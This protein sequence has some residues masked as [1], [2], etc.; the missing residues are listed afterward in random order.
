MADEIL[1]RD[2]NR[3]TVLGGVTDDA[4]QYITMLRVDPV[5]KRLLVSATGSGGGGVTSFNT[6][7][8][9]VVLAAGTN[10]TL[11]PVGNTITIASTGSGGAVDSVFGRTG[12]VTA[13]SGDY[14]TAIVADSSNKRYVTDAQLVVIGNT[15]GTNTGD[16]TNVTGNA[17]TATALQNTRTIWGQNFNGTAN[18]T[19]TLALGTAD[20]T[21]T[22][23]IGATGARATKVWAVDLEVTNMPTVGG[24]SLSSTF[25]ALDA[26]LTAL[27]GYN[28]NGILTQTA[29]DT[30]TGRT[31]T[32]TASRISVSNGDGVSGNP[33]I[34]VDAAYVGQTSIVT[35]GTITTG[36]WQ[37]GSV[38]ANGATTSTS[39]GAQV[40]GST[41]TT[42]ALSTGALTTTIGVSNNFTGVVVRQLLL[43]EAASGTHALVAGMIIRA[44]DLTQGS[45]TT[46][47]GATLYID[48]APT[49]TA[50]IT[51][52]YAI[53]SDSGVNRFDGNVMMS[54]IVDGNNNELVKFTTTA[55]AVNELTISNA[56][57]GGAPTLEA[58]GGDTNIDLF[59]LSKGNGNVSFGAP[60]SGKIV[61]ASNGTEISVQGQA[62]L[63]ANGNVSFVPG[64]VS[65]AV[66][67]LVLANSATGNPVIVAAGGTDTNVSLTLKAKGTGAIIAD[68]RIQLKGYTVATLP[69]GTQGDLAFVTDAL[70]PVYHATVV[71]G[72]AVVTPV[73]YNGTNWIVN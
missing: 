46:T 17:G 21:L 53:W 24:T 42:Y 2:Q 45:A 19:G 12:V 70:T 57:T 4:N 60:G 18:V 29:A 8:G 27:A 55:S 63:D 30:F 32:G 37:G 25:Q 28:T 72:G 61:F 31:I 41:N 66:N 38:L 48:S 5:T 65:S 44:P 26:T 49:G 40:L 39:A 13:Q 52:N 69:T 51:N 33:T 22:G 1:N 23:S 59:F 64:G 11:T 58:T 43:T 34:D 47:N 73:F 3:V 67:Y 7:T 6:L 10:I 68:N 71:G 35:L 9:A 56:A 54:T 36:T 15:S 62:F 16:Q 14:T 50:T 20:L